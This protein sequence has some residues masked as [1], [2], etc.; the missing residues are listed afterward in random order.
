MA[1]KKLDELELAVFLAAKVRNASTMGSQVFRTDKKGLNRREDS[2]WLVAFEL[3]VRIHAGVSPW[4]QRTDA[5]YLLGLDAAY[6]P[7]RQCR[8]AF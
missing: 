2:R 1:S 8:K 5:N 3:S 6:D 7:Y 4:R